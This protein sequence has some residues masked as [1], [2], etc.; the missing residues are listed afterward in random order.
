VCAF[1]WQVFLDRIPSRVNLALRG[2]IKPPESKA[3]VFCQRS[4]ESTTHLLLHCSFTSS[5]WYAVFSWLGVASI[6]PPDLST[7]FAVMADMGGSKRRKSA[8]L[9]LWQVTIWVIWR[10]RNDRLFNNKDVSAI[11]VVDS[12]KQ[13][14]W[15]WYLGRI[16]KQP[17]LLYEWL[18]EPWYCMGL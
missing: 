11:E 18:Q 6:L 15:R 8:L 5:V 12:I 4:D 14:A 9:L 17:C 10:F 16:A 3:C 13:L 1:A 7:G 2:V